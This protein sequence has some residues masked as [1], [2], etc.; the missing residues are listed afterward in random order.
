M[1]FLKN[2]IQMLKRHFISKP[3]LYFFKWKHCFQ[4][5]FYLYSMQSVSSILSIPLE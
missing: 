4:D 2:Q 1:T 5:V 3:N